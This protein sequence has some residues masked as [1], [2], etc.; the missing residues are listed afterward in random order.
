MA[1]WS[2]KCRHESATH[3]PPRSLLVLHNFFSLALSFWQF[4]YCIA[5]RSNHVKKELV[6]PRHLGVHNWFQFASLAWRG[7]KP[8]IIVIIF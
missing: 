5:G 7:Q 1:N 6:L 3:P 4:L 8:L 2:Y